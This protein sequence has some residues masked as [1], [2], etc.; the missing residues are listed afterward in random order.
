MKLSLN[1]LRDFVDIEL[2]V[3][4]LARLLIDCTA[5]VESWETIGAQW[6]AERIR[7][8]EV[9]AIAPHPDAD[10]L[11]LATVETG[12]GL[13]QVVCGAPNLEVGQKVAFAT[14][15][16]ELIDGHTGKPA[17]LKLRPIRGVE[18]AGMVLSEKELGLSEDHE[19]I[20]VLPSNAAV[21]RPLV[22][23]LG[24]VVFDISTWANR[25][26]LLGVLGFGREVSTLTGAVL[27]QPARDHGGS[28]EKAADM[29]S[30]SIEDPDLCARFTASII[31]NVTIG[32]SP[33]WMQERLLRLG[34]RPINNVVDIT[35][36]VMLETGQPLH[37]FDFDHVRERRIVARRASPGERLTTLDGVDRELDPEMLVIC[38]GGGP[39]GIA[40]I[41]GGGNS[42]VSA[43]TRNVLLEVAN[44]RR[45]SIR[46]TSG[47]L[48]LRTEASLRFEKGIGPEMAE[49]AQ[50]RALHLFEQLTGG[51]V[52]GGLVDVY[53]GKQPAKTVV[54]AAA[55]IEQ[56][57]GIAIPEAEVRRILAGLG[58]AVEMGSSGEYRVQPPD[59]RPDVE[60]PDDVV[61]DIGRIYGYDKLPTTTLEG[62][63]PDAP[64]NALRDLRERVRDLA[65]GL[66]FQEIITYSLTEMHKLERVVDPED[67]LRLAQG[68]DECLRRDAVG[69]DD[70]H[71][72]RPAAARRGFAADDHLG[73]VH[74][75]VAKK[76]AHQADAAGQVS[77]G[78][79]HHVAGGHHVHVVAVK[80]RDAWLAVGVDR[81]LDLVVL[82][83][84]DDVH[85]QP[86]VALLRRDDGLHINP[87][88]LGDHGGVDQRNR[89]REVAFQQLG[90]GIPG[91]RVGA[92]GEALAPHRDCLLY[93]SPSPRD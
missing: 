62:K 84:G 44:F 92:A 29:V 80:M 3:P 71:R 28:S 50:H 85:R 65:A 87:P 70:H 57:L 78:Q 72:H 79:Q 8:A 91:N 64:P 7:V 63:L 21:G 27:R 58:F 1:W 10:R 37:A 40:G 81:A 23:Q 86:I 14:E 60:I 76:P 39:V 45:G 36:Y 49:Y 89:L 5:E 67:A 66:G 11:R 35:N 93:T 48:K 24:D 53:P 54:L 13:L 26:D 52:A 15:G 51:T 30:V 74:V 6:D 9:V 32:P 55:R 12:S 16:A 69:L 56:V 75:G 20:L 38:D 31:R 18:S 90:E 4:E 25:A 47:V 73:D 19:G 17:K 43:N 42:E 2:P 68:V 22:E 46:R 61:E 88:L 33:A 83:L 82:A 34:M 59:W 77:V 41:M